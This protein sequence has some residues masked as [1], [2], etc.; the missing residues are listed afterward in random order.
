VSCVLPDYRTHLAWPIEVIVIP[1]KRLGWIIF[2]RASHH[3]TIVLAENL[4]FEKTPI[5]A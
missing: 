5:L 1:A 2:S 3:G 4:L